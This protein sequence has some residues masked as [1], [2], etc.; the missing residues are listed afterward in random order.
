VSLGLPPPRIIGYD[1]STQKIVYD[2]L[3]SV[4]AGQT[5]AVT[6][7]RFYEELDEWLGPWGE[8]GYPIAYG[9]FSNIA[10]TSNKKLLSN[11]ATRDWLWK[12]TILLQEALR[13]YVVQRVKN[14]TLGSLTESQLR[15]AAFESHAKAYTEAGLS[16][17]IMVAPEMLPI[18]ALIP[19]KEFNPTSPNFGPTVKQTL[20]TIVA[21]VPELPARATIP[22][23]LAAFP[24][25][26]GLLQNAVRSD[27]QKRLTEQRLTVQLGQL[28]HAIVKGEVDDIPTLQDLVAR[29]RLLIR[30][31]TQTSIRLSDEGFVR[32]ARQVL[33]AAEERQALIRATY[34]ELLS[35]APKPIREEFETRFGGLLIPLRW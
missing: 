26:S 29:L 15:A 1:D 31:P 8:D 33:S 20:E 7:Y 35:E 12:T 25:H 11:E 5:K 9:K 22:L 18:I 4:I 27:Q 21:V 17:V 14:R 6:T 34:K 24:A 13:D 30:F 3:T 19:R 16:R 28:H 32:Q 2:A 10:F 23:G